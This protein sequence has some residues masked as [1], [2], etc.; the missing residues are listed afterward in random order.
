MP[1]PDAFTVKLLHAIQDQRTTPSGGWLTLTD[2]TAPMGLR[3]NETTYLIRHL[4]ELFEAGM[5]EKRYNADS[6][7]DEWRSRGVQPDL[8]TIM[9]TPGGSVR[10]EDNDEGAA[11][12]ALI[13]LYRHG[14]YVPD[15][16]LCRALSLDLGALWQGLDRLEAAGLIQ[17]RA[18]G[19]AVRLH[20]YVRDMLA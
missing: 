10:V 16:D 13:H 17:R 19:Q 6:H 7:R 15:A 2:M 1:A 11:R 20:E 18:D 12:E 3:Q 4:G 8:R 5:I 14:G 9:A